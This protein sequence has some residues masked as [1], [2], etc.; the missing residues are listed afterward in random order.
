M[1]FVS[2]NLNKSF[3][4]PWGEDAIKNTR[5]YTNTENN[6]VAFNKKNC[7]LYKNISVPLILLF[8]WQGQRQTLCQEGKISE[9]RRSVRVSVLASPW[10]IW[11]GLYPATLEWHPGLPDRSDARNSDFYM[12]FPTCT[13]PIFGC[14]CCLN[15]IKAKPN[16]PKGQMQLAGGRQGGT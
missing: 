3:W 8:I 2:L 14:C 12:K 4:A 6:T 13:N 15:T 16:K 1:V 7:F 11:A 9:W 10:L 5:W